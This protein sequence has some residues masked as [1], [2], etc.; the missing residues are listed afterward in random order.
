MRIIVKSN[1][2]TQCASV[3]EQAAFSVSK[4]KQIRNS[5]QHSQRLVLELLLRKLAFVCGV[6]FTYDK[7]HIQLSTFLYLFARLM[8]GERQDA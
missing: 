8:S 3:R 5:Q 6:N 2:Q 7:N 1:I 4:C